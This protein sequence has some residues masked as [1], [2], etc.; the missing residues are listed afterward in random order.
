MTNQKLD[1]ENEAL[2]GAKVIEA[3]VDILSGDDD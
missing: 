3:D 1:I 2:I